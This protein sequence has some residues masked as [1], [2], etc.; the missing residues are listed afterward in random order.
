MIAQ[1]INAPLLVFQ[2]GKE[3]LEQN[4]FE[5]E[6]CGRKFDKSDLD[7]DE[8]VSETAEDLRGKS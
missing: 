1:R 5:C 4:L 2:P 6:H 3:V 8:C 7:L